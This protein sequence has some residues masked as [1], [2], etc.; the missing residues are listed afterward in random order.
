MNTPSSPASL[1]VHHGD[2]EGR[3]LD[4]VVALRRHVGQR[5]G[6]QRAAQAVADGVDLALAGRLLDRVQ[7]GEVALASCSPRS[8]SRRASRPG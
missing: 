4:P 6:Q 2:E 1:E 7:R 3:G 8:P 5:R